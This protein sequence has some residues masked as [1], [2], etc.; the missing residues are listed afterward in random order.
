MNHEI[1]ETYYAPAPLSSI[2][3]VQEQKT[4][5]QSQPLIRSMLDAL[6]DGVLVLNQERQILMGNRSVLER[7]GLPMKSPSS[8][9]GWAKL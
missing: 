1:R 5:L 4:I 8:G 6:P 2:D 9:S 3:K 7:L